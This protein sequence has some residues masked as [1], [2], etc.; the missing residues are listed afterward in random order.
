MKLSTV[1]G[2]SFFTSKKENELCAFYCVNERDNVV[3]HYSDTVICFK[4]DVVGEP[5]VGSFL[6]YRNRTGNFVGK[7]ILHD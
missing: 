5:K 7:V 3:G 6:E 2:Y 1:V 4:D